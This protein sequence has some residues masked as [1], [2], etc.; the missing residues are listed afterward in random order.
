MS[1]NEAKH[2]TA[3]HHPLR[4]SEL[5]QIALGAVLLTVCAWIVLPFPVPFTL[6]TF[7]LFLILFTLGGRKG[8]Y[9]V[10]VYLLLGLVGLPVFSGFQGGIG[11]LLGATGG[12]LAAFPA[13]AGIY[14]LMT[15]KPGKSLPVRAIACVLGLTACY[16]IGTAWFLLVY[17]RS[18][19]PLTLAAALGWCV[20][21]FIVPDLLKLG[22]ALGLSR[23]LRPHLK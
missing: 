22:L 11:V 9:A 8:L 3:A 12:Y 10:A 21:P 13:A 14:W 2:Q 17:T 20:I 15:A 6:Q 4:T 7:A 19:G 18:T 5:A 23:R 1:A 16:A